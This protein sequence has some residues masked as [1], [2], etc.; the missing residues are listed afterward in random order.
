MS[1]PKSLKD[2][3]INQEINLNNTKSY[4]L[5]NIIS[6][7]ISFKGNSMTRAV[8]YARYSAGPNQTD[9]SIDGQ[10]R[11]C[12]QYIK[13]KGFSYIGHY[14]DRHISGKTDKRP[15][16]QKMINDAEQGLFDV[17]VVYSTDRFS[18]SKY[19]SA[20]YKKKLANLGI[21]ICY[22]A[23]N[24]PDGPEGIL[25]EAL[26]E[27]WA[28]YYSEELSRKIKRGM[29]ESE[30]KAKW[31]GGFGKPLGY[32]ITDDKNFKVDPKTSPYV[33]E[34]Y[35][36]YLAGDNY[37]S[38]RRY[39]SRNGIRTPAGNE[40]KTDAIKRILRNKL[41][42]GT[43]THG[44]TELENAVPR[45]MDDSLFYKV[46]KKMKT[47]KK[48]YTTKGEFL[49]SGKLYCAA[50]GEKMSGTSGTSKTGT[51]HYYYKC[52]NKCRKNISREKLEN[53]I[54]EQVKSTFSKPTELDSLTNKLFILQNNENAAEET[55]EAQTK[56]LRDVTRQI[57]N[58]TNALANRPDSAAL[59]D[60]LDELE[61]QKSDL[62]LEIAA[63]KKRPTLSP[64]AI[65]AGLQVFLDGFYFDD[66]E[67][68]KKRI[69]EAFVHKVVLS[70]SSVIIQFNIGDT[71]GLKT[72]DLIEFDQTT[73][74]W[75]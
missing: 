72:T 53:F 19:D 15:E 27:G 33:I 45:I 16:F 39:L 13:N 25:M 10:L 17:L 1:K 71:D 42:I 70:D 58:I 59:L 48:P 21:K 74:W 3:F 73:D 5:D 7:G 50:C 22:A 2:M 52:K 8:I 68:T 51:V 43:Y 61:A 34:V 28:Q 31:L 30:M 40:Y 4:A 46:Q 47:T 20:I 35:K 26:M 29:R 23:E 69:L 60:K 62:K 66:E 38:I 56:A 12:E 9:Q 57:N 37:A 32:T 75:K 24:I 36:M 44:E 54:V 64:E 6:E 55:T 18:R 11:T 14:A 63:N 67:T 49:L 41:Y 65:K